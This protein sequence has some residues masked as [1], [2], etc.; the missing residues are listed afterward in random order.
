MQYGGTSL[1][2]TAPAA[3][4]PPFPTVTPRNTTPLADSD[5]AAMGEGGEIDKHVGVCSNHD[6]AAV[7]TRVAN[8]RPRMQHRARLHLAGRPTCKTLQNQVEIGPP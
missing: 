4:I 2:T 5:L 1:V 3:T 8:P 6:L 7:T